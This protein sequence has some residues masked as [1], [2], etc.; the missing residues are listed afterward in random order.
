M[1]GPGENQQQRDPAPVGTDQGSA[2]GEHEQY[3]R[4]HWNK[5]GADRQAP[6]AG[7]KDRFH[8]HRQQHQIGGVPAR[9]Q[10]CQDCRQ[11]NG[12]FRWTTETLRISAMLTQ[13][14]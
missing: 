2:Q 14:R 12:P 3:A 5:D 9:E 13:A 4:K 11:A 1:R 8:R 7:E 10:C 6:N